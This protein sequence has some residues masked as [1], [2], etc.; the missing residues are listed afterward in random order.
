MTIV[1]RLLF[2]LCARSE[3]T[4]DTVCCVFAAA[5]PE[6]LRH[7]GVGHDTAH[8]RVPTGA[9]LLLMLISMVNVLSW[10]PLCALVIVCAL[11]KGSQPSPP[12]VVDVCPCSVTALVRLCHGSLSC[13]SSQVS[14]PHL[15][16]TDCARVGMHT[17]Q[18]AFINGFNSYGQSLLLLPILRVSAVIPLAPHRAARWWQWP[19]TLL[20][21]QVPSHPRRTPCSGG[22]LSSMS[23]LLV[24]V[25]M[26]CRTCSCETLLSTKWQ[27][28]RVV[29]DRGGIWDGVWVLHDLKPRLSISRAA[30]GSIVTC[31]ALCPA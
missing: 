26:Q 10:M 16:A 24:L 27:C 15:P 6:R 20:T 8:T 19:M 17:H 30:P 31:A 13:V 7:G 25:C 18:Q 5:G 22:R 29:K 1:I 14:G 21:A 28:T 3:P 12:S 2:G 23:W 9:S 11:V 4:P